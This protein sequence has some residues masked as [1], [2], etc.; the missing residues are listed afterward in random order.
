MGLGL[1]RWASPPLPRYSG[2][3]PEAR[4]DVL[5]T[6]SDPDYDSHHDEYPDRAHQRAVVDVSGH[7]VRKQDLKDRWKVETTTWVLDVDDSLVVG[8][9]G[10]TCDCEQMKKSEH[11]PD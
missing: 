5:W 3:D 8:R 9:V 10:W 1:G 6:W 4:L 11:V 7:R 2:D